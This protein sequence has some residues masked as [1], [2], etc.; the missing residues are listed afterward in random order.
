MDCLGANWH[1]LFNGNKDR[2]NMACHQKPAS[3]IGAVWAITQRNLSRKV[4]FRWIN[5]G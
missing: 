3:I 2:I 4:L 1:L 5:C